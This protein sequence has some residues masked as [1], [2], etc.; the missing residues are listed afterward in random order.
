M[1][2]PI[3]ERVDE[4]SIK[5]YRKEVSKIILSYFNGFLKKKKHI[6]LSRLSIFLIWIL[7]VVFVIS[8]ILYG[9]DKLEYYSQLFLGVSSLV[10]FSALWYLMSLASEYDMKVWFLLLQKVSDN[11]GVYFLK[12]EEQKWRREL[13]S[14]LLKN[15]IDKYSSAYFLKFRVKN[16]GIFSVISGTEKMIPRDKNFEI[17]NKY[18]LFDYQMYFNCAG[19]DYCL[20]RAYLKIPLE[21]NENKFNV[22]KVYHFYFAFP[23]NKKISEE[24]L[25]MLVDYEIFEE[26][27]FTLIVF[28]NFKDIVLQRF[29]SCYMAG[30]RSVLTYDFSLENGQKITDKIA[31]EIDE[32]FFKKI[33]F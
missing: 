31:K 26:Q 18:F 14:I 22:R 11:N 30:K 16:P 32:K 20:A 3:Q 10:V 4:A 2:S 21:M 12:Y 1:W 19:V 15:F 9:D 7:F 25:N 8:G 6:L 29:F 5:A 27:D 24:F 33:R 17:K 13:Y 28:K 23:S